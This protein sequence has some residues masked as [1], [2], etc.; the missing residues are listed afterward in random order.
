MQRLYDLSAFEWIANGL[1][2][3]PHPFDKTVGIPVST[4]LPRGYPSYCKLFPAVYED[5]LMPDHTIGLDEYRRSRANELRQAGYNSREANIMVDREDR[6]LWEGLRKQPE[7]DTTRFQ[8]VRMQAL[9]SRYGVPFHPSFSVESL[10]RAFKN[11]VWP[12]YLVGPHEGSL[13]HAT[14]ER[15]VMLLESFA[16]E[17]ECFFY[18]WFLAT[19]DWNGGDLLYQG[20]LRE[21][22]GTFDWDTVRCSPTYWWPVDRS[23]CV[24]SHYDLTFTLIAGS[25]ELIA[26]LVNDAVLECVSVSEDSRVDSCADQANS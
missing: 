12:R 5:L 18:W 15:L 11:R 24:C 3:L 7:P 20:Q 16:N 25:N 6:E 23:W 19:E 9:A 4:C 17:S 26:T 1:N 13:D 10:R 22:L 2:S 21:I 14:C 8:R